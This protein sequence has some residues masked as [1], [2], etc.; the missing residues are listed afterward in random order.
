MIIDVECRHCEEGKIWRS[1]YGGNDPDVWAER[2][3][4]CDGTGAVQ[5]DLNDEVE[6]DDGEW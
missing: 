1:R 5:E 3:P 4:Y 2:C 6:D